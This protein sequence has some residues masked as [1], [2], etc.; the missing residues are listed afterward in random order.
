MNRI[1]A[2]RGRA[3]H[4]VSKPPYAVRHSSLSSIF[5][6]PVAA[7]AVDD[8]EASSAAAAAGNGAKAVCALL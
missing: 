5:A 8:D 2:A 6:D 1:L 4:V 7:A 3:V